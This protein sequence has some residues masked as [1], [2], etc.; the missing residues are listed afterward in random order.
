VGLLVTGIIVWSV[1]HLYPAIASAARDGL[2]ARMGRN[3]YRGIFS[4]LIVAS[5]AMIVLGWKSTVPTML[6]SPPLSPGM[7]VAGLVFVA[8]VLF[9][10]SQVA[11]N[12]RRLLRHPQLSGVLLWA[13][14]HLLS[15]GDSR[16]LALFGGLGLWAIVEVALCSRRDG[17]WTRPAPAR[18]LFDGITVI[19]AAIAFAVVLYFH[20]WLFG[21]SPI[22]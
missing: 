22:A 18:I 19:I 3:A 4:L 6:Y 1:V 5:L 2:V 8:F 10:A 20:R 14:A 15:N 11:T 21:V 7:A 13:A 17:A 12:I 16:S 9:F